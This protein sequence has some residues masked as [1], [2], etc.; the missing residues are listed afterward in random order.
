MDS[1]IG[2]HL[3]FQRTTTGL[4]QLTGVVLHDVGRITS[5]DLVQIALEVPLESSLHT[6]DPLRY[7]C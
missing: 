5:V 6:N 3:L 1:L 4:D 2:S 7:Y